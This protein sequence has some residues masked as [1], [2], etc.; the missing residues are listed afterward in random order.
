MFK[1]AQDEEIE[2]FN[3]AE[4]VLKAMG[5][6]GIIFTSDQQK[7][8]ERHLAETLLKQRKTS[9]DAPKQ[10]NRGMSLKTVGKTSR[11]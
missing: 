4:H 10:G 8:L 1:G 11:S 9:G 7:E 2:P 6:A 3:I 5:Q